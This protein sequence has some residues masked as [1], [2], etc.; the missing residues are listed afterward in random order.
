MPENT[1][2]GNLWI[3]YALLTVASW[4]LYGVFLHQG[5][6]VNLVLSTSIMVSLCN[7]MYASF[8]CTGVNQGP[9]FQL[10]F[11][12]LVLAILFS[13]LMLLLIFGSP[14]PRKRKYQ[15]RSR[16]VG[17]CKYYKF[18]RSGYPL[19]CS[20]LP[21]FVGCPEMPRCQGKPIKSNGFTSK[22]T[23][24]IRKTDKIQY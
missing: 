20:F 11:S 5:Q 8:R 13:I 19:W 17:E 22:S 4:G 16:W 23:T 6:G 24:N 7:H 18:T 14:G 2:P 15:L 1:G 3:A 9:F 21:C 12:V 10:L